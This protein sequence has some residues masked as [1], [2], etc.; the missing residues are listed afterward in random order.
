MT[1]MRFTILGSGSSGGVPRIGGHWGDC[2]PNNPKNRRRRCSLLIEKV[3]K[4]K[5]TSVII[6]TSPDLR[7]QLLAANVTRL[8]G[9]FYTHFHAD[10]IHGIDDLR[11]VVFNMKERLNVWADAQTKKNLFDRFDYAFNTPKTSPYPPILIMNDLENSTKVD[12]PGGTITITAFKVNHGTID[13]LGFRIDN[14]AYLPDVFDLYDES[15]EA[16]KGLDYLIIDALRRNPH[17]THTHLEKT[18]G[19]INEL[20]PKNAVLTNMHIDMDYDTVCNETADNITPAYD[21]MV[22]E[23]DN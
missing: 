13:S 19:W 15:R 7:D 17:P 9:V 10:H 21:G 11:M 14:L 12:G 18:L 20:T 1:K 22:I 8:D 4:K 2:D 3:S 16:L 5:V 23:L 6:D